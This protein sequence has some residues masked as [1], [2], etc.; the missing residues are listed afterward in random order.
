MEKERIAELGSSV[1]K[2]QDV[3][4]DRRH[5][6]ASRAGDLMSSAQLEKPLSSRES[7]GDYGE[8]SLFC[9]YHHYTP[10]QTD[11]AYM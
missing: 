7:K 9:C 10:N 1:S 8:I 6:M 11:K 2:S 4:P 3:V 5:R